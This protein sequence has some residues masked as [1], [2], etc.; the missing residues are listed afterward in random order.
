MWTQADR[1][2]Y[3][4]DGRRDPTDLTDAQWALIAPLLSSYEPLK[5]DLREMVNACL[6]LGPVVT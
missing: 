1:D 3:E 6:Y 2:F 5:V 4:D